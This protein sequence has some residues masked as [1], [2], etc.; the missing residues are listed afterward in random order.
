MGRWGWILGAWAALG[1]AAPVG[2][3]AAATA[4]DGARVQT[5]ARG[6]DFDR[7]TRIGPVG[8]A[9]DQRSAACSSPHDT[10]TAS[11]P[12]VDGPSDHAHDRRSRSRRLATGLAWGLDGR[13]YA[14]RHDFGPGDVVELDPD[15]R[16]GA[17][18][19]RRRHLQ[20][21]TAPR[22]GPGDRRPLLLHRRLRPTPSAGSSNRTAPAPRVRT[23]Q[24][25]FTVDGLTFGPERRA[26][27]RP[28]PRPPGL[29][30]QRHRR[31]PRPSHRRSPR[32]A[33]PT[34]SRSV[35]RRSTRDAPP[36]LVVNR[37][38]GV[39]TKVDLQAPGAP[40]TDIVT[41][42]SRG[43]LVAV[44]DDGC[45]Y[46]TQTDRVLRVTN[47]NRTVRQGAAAGRWKHGLHRD[48]RGAS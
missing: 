29:H 28:R 14:A 12:T 19:G 48:P 22:H 25:R 31:A 47:A 36:F 10:C 20:C 23:F 11:G 24:A 30:G 2:A 38:D 18:R 13:L 41:G 43:D 44:G 8:V 32:C 5:F 45:L 9:F 15:K 16:V 6:F 46:A 39:I 3:G 35:A 40:Q 21:P 7:A 42:G 34:G 37:T 17:A 27:R 1:L 33:T 4:H 26:L